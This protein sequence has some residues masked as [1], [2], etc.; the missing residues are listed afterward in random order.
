MD[1]QGEPKQ[2][3]RTKDPAAARL[4]CSRLLRVGMTNFEQAERT[5]RGEIPTTP[6]R[7]AG[8]MPRPEEIEADVLAELLASDDAERSDGNARAQLPTAAGALAVT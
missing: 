3:L 7:R 1:R 8:T 2:S 6:S 5:K 4:A